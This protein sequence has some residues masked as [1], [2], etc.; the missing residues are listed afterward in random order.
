MIHAVVLNNRAEPTCTLGLDLYSPSD[1][2]TSLLMK[3]S[4][5][6]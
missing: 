3:S 2:F 6:H 4:F 1:E 5:V